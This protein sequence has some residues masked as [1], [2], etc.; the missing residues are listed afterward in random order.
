[1]SYSAQAARLLQVVVKFEII[2]MPNHKHFAERTARTCVDTH[3]S[4]QSL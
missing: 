4:E 3:L 2:V 1:M